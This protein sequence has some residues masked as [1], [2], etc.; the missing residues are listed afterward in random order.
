MPWR[1]HSGSDPPPI[2][3]FEEAFANTDLPVP[4]AAPLLWEP[5]GVP[6]EW[7]DGVWILKKPPVSARDARR[8][9]HLLQH[10]HL[11]VNAWLV[12]RATRMTDL[13]N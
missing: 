9:Y 5:G 3:I 8:L 2:S 10:V 7:S 1:R 11:H 4:L 12:D 13:E 6:S